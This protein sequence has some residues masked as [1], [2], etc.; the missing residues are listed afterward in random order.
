M[1]CTEHQ[2]LLEC[3]AVEAILSDN[4]RKIDLLGKAFFDISNVLEEIFKPGRFGNK[5]IKV[6]IHI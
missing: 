1:R 2:I 5:G 6:R 3:F 4:S